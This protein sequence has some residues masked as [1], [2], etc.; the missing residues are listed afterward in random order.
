MG[1]SG[2]WQW[3]VE[4]RGF[5]REIFLRGLRVGWEGDFGIAAARKKGWAARIKLF[6]KRREFLLTLN[7]FSIYSSQKR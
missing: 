2:D 3:K 5:G 7:K 4:R 1:R 6:H